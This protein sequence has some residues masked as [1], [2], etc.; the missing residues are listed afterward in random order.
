LRHLPPELP[1]VLTHG[2]KVNPMS[3][4]PKFDLEIYS[5]ELALVSETEYDE[6]METMAADDFDGY[7]EWSA[8]I[9]Q[10]E[11]EREQER[12]GTVTTE[13]GAMLLKRDCSHK[14]CLTTRCSL[15]A[16]FGGIAI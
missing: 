16:A 11:F 12:R 4:I 6:I 14:A 13:Y 5:E 9:E 15:G 10:A 8:T 2:R 7:S 3:S 1:P